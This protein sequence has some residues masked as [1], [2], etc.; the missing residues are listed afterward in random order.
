MKVLPYEPSILDIYHFNSYPRHFGAPN[1]REVSNFSI[2][3][4]YIKHYN[5]KLPIFISHNSYTKDLVLFQ[6]MPWDVDTDKDGN[7]LEMAYKDLQALADRYHNNEILLTFSGSGFHFYTEFEPTFIPLSP[8]L[9]DK[10]R[11]Y[12]RKIVEELGLK[13]VNTSCAESKRLIRI[14]TTNYV[15][16][17]EHSEFV[18]TDRYAIPINR[19]ILESYSVKDILRLAKTPNPMFYEPNL[20][21]KRKLPIKELLE[22]KVDEAQLHTDYFEQE[23]LDWSY[24]TE[25]QLK[26]YLSYIMDEK[27][28]KDLWEAHPSHMT[29]F[30]ACIKIKEYGLSA[31]SAIQIFDRVSYYAHWNNRNVAKQYHQ[32]TGIYARN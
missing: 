27:M 15:Y 2:L 9:N 21:G 31:S 8:R 16:Q 30:M 13:T 3:N 5:G 10:M 25:E 7:T 18:Q 20:N 24:L 6:Q 32:I 26:H 14:P 1:Q 4:T 11:N 17:N 19:R 28:L 12:Q 22:V 23:T 29:R